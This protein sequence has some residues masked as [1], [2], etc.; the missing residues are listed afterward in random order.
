MLTELTVVRSSYFTHVPRKVHDRFDN[1]QKGS[2]NRGNWEVGWQAEKAL[3]DFHWCLFIAFLQFKRPISGPL[4]YLGSRNAHTW[5]CIECIHTGLDHGPGTGATSIVPP[6]W[7]TPPT[8]S[9]PGGSW[10]KNSSWRCVVLT[11]NEDV[12]RASAATVIRMVWRMRGRWVEV[13]YPMGCPGLQVKWSVNF[14]QKVGLEKRRENHIPF[15]SGKTLLDS[16]ET[17]QIV[18]IWLQHRHCLDS[19]LAFSHHFEP[20]KEICQHRCSVARDTDAVHHLCNARV[21][22][23]HLA[24]LPKQF[25]LSFPPYFLF[26]YIQFCRNML[27]IDRTEIMKQRMGTGLGFYRLGKQS[28]ELFASSDNELIAVHPPNVDWFIFRVLRYTNSVGWMTLQLQ[29]C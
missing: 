24:R 16:F 27:P 18:W 2:T 7:W 15:P 22:I 11:S 8:T 23:K 25:C 3:V 13:E 12:P 17:Q 19:K 26:P 6:L 5:Y 10:T 14:Y 1:H 28:L 29:L 20:A 4:R 9:A 21:S